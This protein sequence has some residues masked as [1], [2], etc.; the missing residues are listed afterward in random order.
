MVGCLGAEY[1]LSKGAAPL[2]P[3]PASGGRLGAEADER[4]EWGGAR[5]GTGRVSSIG[6]QSVAGLDQHLSDLEM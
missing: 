3:A 1:L 6:K 5:G 4:Q 2:A